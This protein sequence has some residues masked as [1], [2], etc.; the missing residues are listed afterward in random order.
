MRGLVYGGR[1]SGSP[2][3]QRGAALGGSA[4]S[5]RQA[6]RVP[7][8]GSPSRSRRSPGRLALALALAR[9]ARPAL[10]GLNFGPRSADTRG[11]VNAMTSLLFAAAQ[12][13]MLSAS[14]LPAGESGARFSRRSPQ[15]RPRSGF[16]AAARAGPPGYTLRVGGGRAPGAGTPWRMH[17]LCN[18]SLGRACQGTSPC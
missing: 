13:E 8:V 18:G 9:R 15:R 11:S 7:G 1:K 6:V 12:Q 16:G 2:C 14:P 17:L 3:S 5:M 10:E 4:A